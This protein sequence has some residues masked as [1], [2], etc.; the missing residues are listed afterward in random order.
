MTKD[1]ET[2]HEHSLAFMFPK[3]NVSSIH[4]SIDPMVFAASFSQVILHDGSIALRST[5]DDEFKKTAKKVQR[6]CRA[7]PFGKMLP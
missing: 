7:A 5:G 3:Y 1:T 4:Q 6:C 2:N